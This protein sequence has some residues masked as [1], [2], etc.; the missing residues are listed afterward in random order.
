[1]DIIKSQMEASTIQVAK[2][3]DVKCRDL[4]NLFH[5]PFKKVEVGG[6]WVVQKDDKGKCILKEGNDWI[7]YVRVT[8]F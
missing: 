8:A 3:L 7:L 5:A 4:K 6:K 1:M 2:M